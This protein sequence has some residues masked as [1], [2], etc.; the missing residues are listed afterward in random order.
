MSSKD[1]LPGTPRLFFDSHESVQL[2]KIDY[3]KLNT[4]E[5]VKWE[6]GDDGNSYPHLYARLGGEFVAEVKVVD[7]G[8]SWSETAATFGG[9]LVGVL[10]S[11]ACIR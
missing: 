3:G 10:M 5:T 2:L 11:G 6:L 4:A 1:Q 7:K 9:R 8:T